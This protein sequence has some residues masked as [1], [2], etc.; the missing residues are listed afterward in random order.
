MKIRK[1]LLSICACLLFVLCFLPITPIQASADTGPKPS[2][3]ITVNG[4]GD[5]ECYATLL[6]A[7]ENNGP[8]GK[9][10]EDEW[11]DS[12]VP[13]EFPNRETMLLFKEYAETDG[14]YFYG[15][16]W[17]LS[18]GE[19][20]A[21]T[22]YPPSRFKLLLYFP[23]TETFLVSQTY[24]TYAFHSYYQTDVGRL[25]DGK[26]SLSNAYGY[27]REALGLTARVGITVAVE[28]LIALLYRFRG[29][30]F[31]LLAGVNVGTQILLNIGLNLFGVQPG[32][33]GYLLY[34]PAYLFLEILVFAIESFVY[35]RF[36]NRLAVS[37]EEKPKKRYAW[38]ALVANVASFVIGIM[39][40]PI[41][42]SIF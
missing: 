40:A 9:W 21:W 28:L 10:G 11:Y 3:R 26:L 37:G 35:R 6:G 38:Y 31:L 5:K 20:L 39:I 14:F 33:M 4:L 42:P 24:V 15:R 34:I 25:S 29:K 22:Y 2:V 32:G 36:M 30:Q 7:T 17:K 12:S 27:G 41:F 1:F 19:E 8:Y 16:G 13:N 18:D 23:D